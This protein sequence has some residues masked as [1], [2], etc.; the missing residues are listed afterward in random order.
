MARPKRNRCKFCNAPV[1]KARWETGRQYCMAKE[2][3][4]QGAEALRLASIAVS[5]SIPQIVPAET[6][7]P[8][9]A[10]SGHRRA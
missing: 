8:T 5:K 3:I 10:R 9:V 7:D 4:E 1:A 2:C 6:V